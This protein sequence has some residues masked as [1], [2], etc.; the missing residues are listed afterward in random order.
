MSS[1]A[2]SPVKDSLKALLQK[3][4]IE[5]VAIVDD[6][7]DSM[8]QRGLTPLEANDLWERLEFDD[9]FHAQLDQLGRNVETA[10]DLAGELIDELLKNQSRVPRFMDVWPKSI[11]GNRRAEAIEPV[12]GLRGQLEGVLDLDVRTFDSDTEPSTLVAYDPQLLFLDWYLGDDGA[13][14]VGTTIGGGETHPAVQAAVTKARAILADWPSDRPKPLIVLMS[15]KPGVEAAAGVFCREAEI[16]RGMFYAVPKSTLNDAFNLR[17][18]LNLFAMSV[19]AGRRLQA[20][21]DALRHEF[22]GARKRFLEAISDLTL[23]DYAYIQRL[24][25]QNE[26]QPLGDYLLWLFST[27]LGQL[28]FAEALKDVRN[29]LDSMTFEQALPSLGPPSETLTDI[30]HTALF[31]TSVGPVDSH[32]LASASGGSSMRI[33]PAIALGDVLRY[34]EPVADVEQDKSSVAEDNPH[35]QEEPQSPSQGDVE[36]VDRNGD[37]EETGNENGMGGDSN[38]DLLVLINA[39]CDLA[40]RPGREDAPDPVKD[41]AILLL[42]GSLRPLGT[43][44]SGASMPKTELYQQDGQNYRIEW[45]TKNVQAIPLDQFRKWMES[46]CY[47]RS[48][49]LRLPLALEIQRAFATDLTRIG[50]PVSPPIY[51]PITVQLLRPNSQGNAYEIIDDLK[52]SEAAFLVLTRN[53]QQCVLTL[54]LIA[55]LAKLLQAKEVTI[56]EE[57][58]AKLRSPFKPPASDKPWPFSSGRF[59]IDRG[60][61]EG[62]ECHPSIALTL[63]IH[64]D[65]A[66]CRPSAIMGHPR[67]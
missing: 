2:T 31:D 28:L 15:S 56:Q 5:R 35:G 18:H 50:S 46:N 66:D 16:L 40:F 38:P 10:E 61:K 47:E 53:G 26:G 33:H 59:R 1:D 30:Y 48:A 43:K 9:D 24:C 41:L 29:D 6:A 32:P 51:Q 20:F 12:S 44:S 58:W 60:A 8:A 62:Q 36:S 37:D 27:Y 13:Q 34:Q 63:G 55:K 4:G 65:D 22:L 21:M 17:L 49:R 54:P 64:I 7:F 3:E 39:Q 23:T 19:P 14:T 25:L 42:P 52:E 45:D 67:G 11:A 57:D